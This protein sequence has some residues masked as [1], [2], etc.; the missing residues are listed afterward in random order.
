[1]STA[2]ESVGCL[3]LVDSCLDC[4][5]VRRV[6]PVQRLKF[7]LETWATGPR[8]G[9]PRRNFSLDQWEIWEYD[10][11]T[12]KKTAVWSLLRGKAWRRESCSSPCEA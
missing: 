9:F 11:K 12:M 7:V 3:A 1:M 4:P 2:P 8:G 10:P 6:G 5:E